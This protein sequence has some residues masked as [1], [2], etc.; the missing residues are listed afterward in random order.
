MIQIVI[1]NIETIVQ[2]IKISSD[3]KN[4]LDRQSFVTLG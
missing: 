1:V 3:E 2:I 4:N